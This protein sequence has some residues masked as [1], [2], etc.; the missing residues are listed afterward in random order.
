MKDKIKEIQFGT[1]TILII[2]LFLRSFGSSYIFWT[3]M[4][5]TFTFTVFVVWTLLSI[6]RL[7]TYE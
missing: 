7:G 6:Y 4:F 1:Q 2:C 3:D 5:T